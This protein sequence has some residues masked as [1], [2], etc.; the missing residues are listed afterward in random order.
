MLERETSKLE[1]IRPPFPRISYTDALEV[2]KEKGSNTEWGTDL[3]ATDE[4][5][6]MEDLTFPFSLQLSER[7]EGI[8]YEGKP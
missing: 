4:A 6:L 2:L 8:L 3:G 5:A 1:G 7:C